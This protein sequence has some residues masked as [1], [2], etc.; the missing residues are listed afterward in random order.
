M[1]HFTKNDQYLSFCYQ[2]WSQDQGQEVF[3]GNR[4]FEV[5]EAAEVNEA[6][7]VSK[8]LKI[9]TEVFK[10]IHV[11]EFNSLRTNITL[12]WNCF[13]TES[14]KIML[15]F[16]TFSVGGCWGHFFW[17]LVDETQMPKP[18]E[19]TDTFILTKKLFLVGFHGLQS[20]SKPIER[21]CSITFLSRLVLST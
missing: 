2:W 7:K 4:A 11:L 17:K 16:S 6:K 15:N 18:Q 8:G 3:W 5:A 12:F 13:L 9:T 14:G 20:M 10:V 21:P 1:L 19:Y